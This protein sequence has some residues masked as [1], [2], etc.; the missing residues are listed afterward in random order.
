LTLDAGIVHI[1]V[2]LSIWVESIW[3]GVDLGQH[4]KR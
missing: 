4:S 1:G 3:V 2:L